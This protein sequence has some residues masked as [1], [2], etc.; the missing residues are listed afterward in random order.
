MPPDIIGGRG[1]FQN[2]VVPFD[3]VVRDATVVSPAGSRLV[4]VAIQD[5][6]FVEV[7]A[8]SERGRDELNA[9]G[10]S[11]MPGVID[12]QVHFREPGME[13]KED[14]ESGTR[15]A[16]CGG[17]T[18]VFE[19]PN[20]SPPTTTAEAL[21]DKLLRARGRAWCDHGFFV[22][23]SGENVE[24]LPDL[25]Q[26]AGS[27]GVKVFVGSSTGTLLVEDDEVLSRVLTAGKMRCALH[28]EDEARLRQRRGLASGRVDEHPYVRDAESAVLATRR[29]LRLASEAKRPIH[30]LHVSTGDEPAL[31]IAAKASGQDVTAE[32]TPQHLHFAA[33]GAYERL[34]SLVQMNPPIRED[35]HRRA[36]WRALERGVFDVF[37]SDH[38]PHTLEEKQKPYGGHD[39]S[40]SGMPGVQT[41]LPVLL[42][43]ARAGRLELTK[44]VDMACSKPAELFGLKGKGLV[45]PGYDADFVLFDPQSVAVLNRWEVQSKCG[46]SPFE[47]EELAAFPRA[48]YLRGII[49]A[50]DGKP[51]GGQRGLP[52]RFTWKGST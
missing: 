34:G 32:V 2:R 18:T 11:L 33:P 22:G 47:G 17:V 28:C 25:E 30:I 26:L 15:A 23:A 37:G 45:E 49:A 42:S 9:Q 51:V 52:V 44:L 27:P 46:W 8:I 19:M 24:H 29:I 16:I 14:I 20:T 48:V 1:K 31:I 13:H 3:L 6:I 43:F 38:A 40:P 10:L 7:G 41:M 50:K 36:L 21:A 4:D 5:G 39:G 12:T 35:Y